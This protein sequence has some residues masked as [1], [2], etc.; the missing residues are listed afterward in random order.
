VD[1]LR[2]SMPISL[3]LDGD[4]EGGNRVT[5]MRFTVP[6]GEADPA[7]RLRKVHD[8]AAAARNEPSVPH[9]GAIAAGLSPVT[10]LAVAPMALH[11]DFAASNVPGYGFPVHLCGAEVLRVYPFGPTGGSAANAT[12]ITYSG[13][14]CIGVNVDTAAVPHTDELLRCLAEGFGEVLTL[15]GAG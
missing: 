3:R 13:T 9:F 10:P 2:M 8:V 15:A 5:V 12:M 6:V 4:A 1:E 14:C 11:M 7:E